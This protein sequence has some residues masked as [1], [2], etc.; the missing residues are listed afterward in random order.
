MAAIIYRT[1]YKNIPMP[2]AFVILDQVNGDDDTSSIGGGSAKTLQKAMSL[3]E[4]VDDTVEVR[5]V[6]DYVVGYEETVTKQSKNTCIIKCVNGSKITGLQRLSS[7]SNR[8]NLMPKIIYA[9]GEYRRVSSSCHWMDAL[10]YFPFSVNRIINFRKDGNNN[11]QEIEIPVPSGVSMQIDNVLDI[12][13]GWVRA[14]GVITSVTD[15]IAVATV[16]SKNYQITTSSSGFYRIENYG[17]D[18]NGFIFSRNG[19]EYIINSRFT[20][21]QSQKKS[22][23]IFKD[24]F[25]V[26]FADCEISCL[27]DSNVSVKFEDCYAVSMCNCQFSYCNKVEAFQCTDTLVKDSFFLETDFKSS[28][29]EHLYILNNLFKHSDISFER[30]GGLIEHN[31]ICYSFKGISSGISRTLNNPK[32]GKMVVQYNELHHI[33]LLLQADYGVLY[34]YGQSDCVFQYNYIHDCVGRNSSGSITGIY[35]DEGAYGC[36]C[37][38]NIILNCTS[39]SYTHFSCGCVMYNNLFAYPLQEQIRYSQLTYEGGTSY[40]GNIFYKG[41]LNKETV[42]KMTQDGAHF[43]FNMYDSEIELDES[44]RCNCN[45]KDV[46]PFSN[47][48]KANFYIGQYSRGLISM[49]STDVRALNQNTINTTFLDKDMGYGITDSSA[50]KAQETFTSIFTID[51]QEF[52]YD[53]WFKR[54]EQKIYDVTNDYLTS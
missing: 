53:V 18:S 27:G 34:I 19:E 21:V 23:L 15:G 10:N 33:G 26:V 39:S 31:T 41:T 54:C 6:S 25:N 3:V 17:N 35:M 51:S 50:W 8:T 22:C 45:E 28:Y 4:S 40:V 1:G 48:S 29:G 52:P 24:S 43:Q 30:E 37:R 9:D 38:Y 7:V 11:I 14:T 16:N 12:Q 42:N 20:E 32:I 13:T 47:P 5:I 46:P 2:K 49:G 44:T 36:L